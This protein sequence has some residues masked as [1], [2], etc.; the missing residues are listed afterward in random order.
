MTGHFS[1]QSCSCVR[2]CI[3]ITC[4]T[5]DAI[6]IQKYGLYRIENMKTGMVCSNGLSWGV[7]GIDFSDD[8]G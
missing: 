6:G 8:A 2:L 4:K 1:S 5:A 3:S 7:A